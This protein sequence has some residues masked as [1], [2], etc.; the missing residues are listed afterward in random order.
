MNYLFIQNDL[1]KALTVETVDFSAG[2]L[3]PFYDYDTRTVYL[4]GKVRKRKVEFFF[5]SNIII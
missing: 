4:A 3:I 1:S 2:A 5:S